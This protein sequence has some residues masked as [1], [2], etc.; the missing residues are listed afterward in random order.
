MADVDRRYWYG[1]VDGRSPDVDAGHVPGLDVHVEASLAIGPGVKHPAPSASRISPGGRALF[2]HGDGRALMVPRRTGFARQALTARATL[3]ERS[4]VELEA[5]QR[6]MKLG[7]AA[8]EDPRLGGAARRADGRTIN[9]PA[10]WLSA[11]R[12]TTRVVPPELAMSS[13]SNALGSRQL[14]ITQSTPR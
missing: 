8:V 7:G 3:S 5:K 11:S 10:I 4:G 2:R 9:C 12:S 6:T 1:F 14:E 13:L